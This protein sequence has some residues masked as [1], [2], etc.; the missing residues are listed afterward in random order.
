VT[1]VVLPCGL[2]AI[3]GDAFCGYA[4]LH[5]LAVQPGCVTI[6]GGTEL[7]KQRRRYEGALAGCSSLVRANIP[8]TCAPIG[9]FTGCS[10]LVNA[11]VPSGVTTIGDSAFRDC[12]GLRRLTIP[13]SLTRVG[14]GDRDVFRDVSLDRVTPI[15]SPLDRVVA[16]LNPALAPGARV[17]SAELAGQAFGRFAIVAA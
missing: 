9:A 6:E 2:T 8:A 14:D 11:A 10:G 3:A 1:E 15:G 17:I 7:N 16:T 12:S 13:A 5:S 4:M